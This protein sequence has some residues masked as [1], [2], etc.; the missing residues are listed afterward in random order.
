MSRSD[1]ES[2]AARVAHY[3]ENRC[4]RS[5]KLTV[6][7]FVEEGKSKSTIYTIL[8]RYEETGQ[9]KFKLIPGRPPIESSPKKV[10]KVEK[11]FTKSPSVSVRAAARKLNFKRST[12]S[13]IKVHKLGITARTKIKAPKYVKD[14]EARAKT[15]CRKILEKC[16]K[17]VLV[18]DDE[19][20]VPFDPSQL[21]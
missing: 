10:K 13:D 4:G 20:Y 3:F 6:R 8:K 14:Q 17:K 2:F 18:I 11:V 7:H 9:V 21:P 19:T 15:G 5:K 16:R 1:N 12:V